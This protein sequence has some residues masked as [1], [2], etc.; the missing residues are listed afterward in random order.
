MQYAEAKQA[1]LETNLYEVETALQSQETLEGQKLVTDFLRTC[2]Q[3]QES[4]RT[5][6]D[7]MTE[8]RKLKQNLLKQNNKYVQSLLA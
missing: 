4:T 2:K 6:E 5:D 7:M 1:Q 8:I 3:I